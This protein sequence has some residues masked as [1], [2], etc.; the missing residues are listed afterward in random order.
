MEAS[1]IGAL[2]SQVLSA[3]FI[4]FI[5]IILSGILLQRVLPPLAAV[6]EMRLPTFI[7]RIGVRGDGAAY[8]LLFFI[9]SLIVSF[10]SVP[11]SAHQAFVT[12]AGID[13]KNWMFFLLVASCMS[14]VVSAC[15][16]FSVETLFYNP[17]LTKEERDKQIEEATKIL[18]EDRSAGGNLNDG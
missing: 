11:L 5:A 4:V 12:K 2:I 6:G 1:D 18:A 3:P 14:L 17:I 16:F 8:G 15:I 13:I 10:L 7:L 9:L